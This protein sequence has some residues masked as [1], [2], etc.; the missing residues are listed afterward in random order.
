VQQNRLLELSTQRIEGRPQSRT[1][2]V[3]FLVLLMGALG[4]TLWMMRPYLLALIMGGILALLCYRPYHKLRQHLFKSKLAGALITLGV[5]LLVIIPLVIFINLAIKQGIAFG[6]ELAKSD[7]FSLQAI[8]NQISGWRPVQI[9]IGNPEDFQRQAR[10][11]IQGAG[12]IVTTTI[13]GWAADLPK[14]FLQIILALLACF[15]FLIDGQKFVTWSVDKIPLDRDVRAKV[16]SSFESTAVSVIWATLAAAAAQSLIM[17]FSFIAL[18]VPSVF[19]AAGATFIFAWIPILGSAPI[20]LAGAFYLYSQG[21]LVKTVL[22]VVLG[23]ITSVVDNIVRPQVL[24]GRGSMHPF[25]SL[26]GIL[27]GVGMF[28][29]M[30]IF[31]GPILMAVLISL[32]QIWPAVGNRFGL[33]GGS[34]DH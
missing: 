9:M 32:L 15:F 22:M 24:K 33:M 7:T 29:I 2:L 25:V 27:G 20:W 16:A 31:L 14:M 34:F 8:L 17:F 18:G 21:F 4:I 30:G 23:L 12:Q 19:L 13:L 1:T 6:Q 5:A 10:S 28:G 3:T 11:W 26:I